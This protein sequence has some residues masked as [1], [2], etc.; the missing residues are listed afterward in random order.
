M[1]MDAQFITRD[2]MGAPGGGPMARRGA[3]LRSGLL[4]TAFVLFG[5]V[6]VINGG[7]VIAGWRAPLFFCE[8][9]IALA[10]ALAVFHVAGQLGLRFAK[11]VG[12]GMGAALVLMLGAVLPPLVWLA[13]G[14]RG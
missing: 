1:R 4:A 10:A 5:W 12:W 13:L 8:G 3:A 6:T 7:F 11:L 14:P 9:Q 2:F